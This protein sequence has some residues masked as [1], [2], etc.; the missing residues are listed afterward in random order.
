MYQLNYPNT[1]VKDD[2]FKLSPEQIPEHDVLIPSCQPFS[3]SGYMEG[4]LN[5]DLKRGN[6][7]FKLLDIIQYHKTEYK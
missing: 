5:L 4:H 6:H 7:F 2:I 1:K 3:R